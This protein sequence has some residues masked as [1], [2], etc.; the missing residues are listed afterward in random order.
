M[1]ATGDAALAAASELGGINLATATIASAQYRQVPRWRGWLS[2]LDL[3]P[4]LGENIGSARWF[5]GLG[6]LTLLCAG[7][8]SLLPDYGPLPAMVSAVPTQSEFEEARA[9]MIT[10]LALGGD[11]GKKMGPTENVIALASSPERP[12]I[13]VL[14]RFGRGDSF[15]RILTRSGLGAEEADLV[16]RLVSQATSL[17]DIEPGTALEII[18]GRRQSRN[19]P[20]PLENLTFRA[21]F[22]LSLSVVQAGNGLRLIRQPI[23]V[24]KTPLRIR[25]SVGGNGLYRSARAAGVPASVLQNYLKILGQQMNLSSVRAAD[26]FDIIMDHQRAE[27]GEIRTGDLRYAGLI[28]DGKPKVQLMKWQSGG[29][30]QWF[31]ASGAGEN[32]GAMGN[33]VNGRMSSNYG[34]RRHPIL[35]YKRMHAGIDFKAGYGAPIYAANDG[36]VTYA[37]RKGGFGNYVR[38]NHG[39]GIGTGY[40]HMSK[41]AAKNGQ[42][43]R[44]GQIIGYVGSTGLSTGPHLHYELYKGGKA[45]NPLS[46][47]FTQKAQLGGSDLR[48][49]KAELSRLQS[50][51]VGEALA[52]IKAAENSKPKVEREIDRL[53]RNT[54]VRS[55]N[56]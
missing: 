52:P 13:E 12:R 32:R 31:E 28:R 48:N 56:I 47:K 51:G 40:G 26:E 2:T 6:T 24:D 23:F 42:R 33:P 41:I 7:A 22:D 39:G 1:F 54:A 53:T 44:R 45:V 35:G 36:T 14:A 20:R 37:G 55:G 11:T 10:P 19:Q 15:G 3:V 4:D 29:S 50:V 18:L 8:L 5:R 46:V 16:T 43:V 9:Q 30:V 38:I 25:G 49:F 34:M 21:R 27:T 17:K